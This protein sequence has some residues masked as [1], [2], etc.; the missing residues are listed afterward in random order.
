[1]RLQH[2]HKTEKKTEVMWRNTR[3]QFFRKNNALI[4]LEIRKYNTEAERVQW[5]FFAI[6]DFGSKR[7]FNL[8]SSPH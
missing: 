1:M 4:R 2:P 8:L 3:K 5:E 6:G 7:L